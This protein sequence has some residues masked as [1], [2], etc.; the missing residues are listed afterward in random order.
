VASA[1]ESEEEPIKWIFS[2]IMDLVKLLILLKT[3]SQAKMAPDND[4]K[5]PV[6]CLLGLDDHHP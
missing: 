2:N 4:P 1:T 3:H 6:F 5:H